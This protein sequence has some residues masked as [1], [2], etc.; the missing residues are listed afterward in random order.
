MTLNS[1]VIY[2]SSEI[3]SKVT[4]RI[5]GQRCAGCTGEGQSTS[6]RTAFVW[7]DICKFGWGWTVSAPLFVL[8]LNPC[9][10]L[11]GGAE[12]LALSDVC[13]FWVPIV[14][15]LCDKTFFMCWNGHLLVSGKTPAKAAILQ[16]RFWIGFW[17][18]IMVADNLLVMWPSAL[19][20][21]R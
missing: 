7:S 11:V 9:K 18:K 8:Q 10:L 17:D 6:G 15:F 4:L 19:N 2:I 1:C 20:S 21:W 14:M 13:S 5:W 12:R 3:Y 16:T